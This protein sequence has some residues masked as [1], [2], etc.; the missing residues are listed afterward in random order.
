MTPLCLQY[1]AAAQ[2]MQRSRD[3]LDRDITGRALDVRHRR[4]HLALGGTFEIA[5][6]LF[7]D[8][9]P[10]EGCSLGFIVR[11]LRVQLYFK[12]SSRMCRHGFC[13]IVVRRPIARQLPPRSAA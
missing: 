3:L 12:R 11:R 10:A 8:G 9:Q 5:V 7:L 6:E 13:S 4:Q 1:E 2:A